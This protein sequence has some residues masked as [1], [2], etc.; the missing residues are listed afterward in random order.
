[1]RFHGYQERIVGSKSKV[2]LLRVLFNFSD[3]E[4]TGDDLARKAGVSKPAAHEALSELAVENVVSRRVA[5]RAYLYSLSP[6]SYSAKLVAPLFRPEDSPLEEMARVVRKRLSAV[7][8]VSAILFGSIARGEEEE[9]SDLDLYL[10]V[11][12]NVERKKA[13]AKISEL[14][15]L[16]TDYFGNRLSAMIK[17]VD[18]LKHAYKNRLPLETEVE[19]QGRVLLG[20]SLREAAR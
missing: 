11:R 1:M 4:F 5:G 9:Q 12:S 8:L 10:V 15:R 6:K 17:T 20:L 13:E 19:K 16:T 18:E 2:R 7:P 3:S 14:N